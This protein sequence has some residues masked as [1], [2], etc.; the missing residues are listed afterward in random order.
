MRTD[1]QQ[2]GEPIL[3]HPLAVMDYR[4]YRYWFTLLYRSINAS[5]SSNILILSGFIFPA[6]SNFLLAFNQL[7]ISCS[8]IRYF[9]GF[10]LLVS[11]NDFI[12][13]I[14]CQ[15]TFILCHRKNSLGSQNLYCYT[16]SFSFFERVPLDYAACSSLRVLRKVSFSHFMHKT[17]KL[18]AY[19]PITFCNNLIWLKK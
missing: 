13:I 1:K 8:S 7:S 9:D 3:T 17:S 5:N 4:N 15:P 19:Y 18:T 11:I 14:S 16:P 10:R 12:S 2:A 6:F